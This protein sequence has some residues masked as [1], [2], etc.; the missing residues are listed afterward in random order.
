MKWIAD[1]NRITGPCK[2]IPHDVSGYGYDCAKNNRV[3]EKNLLARI[4]FVK[5]EMLISPN[6]ITTK[7]FEPLEIF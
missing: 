6:N 3:P 5:V 4:E 2:G 7:H 1:L